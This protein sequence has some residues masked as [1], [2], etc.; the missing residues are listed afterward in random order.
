MHL[1]LG[2]R[3]PTYCS[4]MQGRKRP[5]PDDGDDAGL[6]RLLTV[7]VALIFLLPLAVF[8]AILLLACTL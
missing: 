6:R 4:L 1:K 3:I 8:I 7:R 2:P 5:L